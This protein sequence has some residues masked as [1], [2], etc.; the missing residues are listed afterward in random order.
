MSTYGIKLLKI[1]L[2]FITILYVLSIVT[3]AYAITK[4][5]SNSHNLTTL[6][7][8]IEKELKQQQELDLK[9]RNIEKEK[10]EI[11]QRMVNQANDIQGYEDKIIDIEKQ[12]SIL[13]GQESK[14]KKQL[15]IK[16]VHTAK[17]LGAIERIAAYPP[18]ALVF[19][20]NISPTNV[21]RSA[22]MMRS[23]IPQVNSQTA[24]LRERLENLIETEEQLSRQHEE[25]KIVSKELS[26]HR[27]NIEI[28]YAKLKQ[29]SDTNT[30]QQKKLSSNISNLKLRAKNMRTLIRKLQ[31]QQQLREAEEKRKKIRKYQ[32]EQARK[33]RLAQ[34]ER[35][36]KL[37]QAKEK[38]L[39]EQ[40]IARLRKVNAEK[41]R[42]E[43]LKLK[44]Q[45]ARLKKEEDQRKAREKLALKRT[46]HSDSLKSV[47]TR[48]LRRHPFS[49]AFHKLKLPVAGVLH[50]NYN[51]R[52]ADGTR[53]A[54]VYISTRT[55]SQVVAPYA[56]LIYFAENYRGY[57]P[58]IIIEYGPSYHVVLYGMKNI[59]I[60]AGQYVLKGD[61][62]ARMGDSKI[63]KIEIRHNMSPI[64]PMRWLQ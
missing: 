43:S 46:K 49:H 37:K 52:L 15:K 47:V 8:N 20:P 22:I 54:S 14:L 62:I 26:G 25:L 13:G 45:Q 6:Q 38:A 60:K 48:E 3:N 33:K 44:Q 11:H 59:T 36:R 19:S 21:V 5:N 63:L 39:K 53:Q 4:S 1:I 55:N 32:L 29:Q 42:Q 18:E 23:I 24:L 41:A 56:G 58:M 61:P 50:N 7:K 10:L 35:S 64:N 27:Q 9:Q 40:E 28:M 16:D 30:I 12:I 57:G 17:L 34:L 2:K 51:Y 31:Q